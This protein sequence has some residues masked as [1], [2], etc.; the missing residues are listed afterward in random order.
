M[1]AAMRRFWACVCVVL[2]T[3]L[4]FI[5]VLSYHP[6]AQPH[7][8]A[9]HHGADSAPAVSVDD[10]GRALS[11]FCQ[12]LDACHLSWSLLPVPAAR[13]DAPAARSILAIG[14]WHHFKS[15]EL[16]QPARPPNDVDGTRAGLLSPLFRA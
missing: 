2:G 11:A 8:P 15:A 14:P 10:L 3:A 13:I 5:P 9:E 4:T 7:G 6:H 1:S 12:A 16:D